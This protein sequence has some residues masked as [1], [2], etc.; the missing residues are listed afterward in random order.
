[1]ANLCGDCEY[2]NMNDCR[3]G[4]RFYCSKIGKYISP[5]NSACSNLVLRNK[6]DNGYQRSGCFITTVVC[7]ILGYDDDCEV[8][9][10]LRNFRDNF[11]KPN[12][13]Y[14][15]ILQEYD[16]VGPIISEAILHEDN[17]V[18]IAKELLQE[19]IIPCTLEIKNG[20]Y[21]SAFWTY[22][23]MVMLLKNRYNLN[24][25]PINIMYD[26]PIEDLGKGRIRTINDAEKNTAF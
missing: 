2:L 15:Y 26:T 9:Y 8:L 4:D 3:W 6:K 17:P 22:T 14:H 12:P 19:Y 7:N 5:N 23:L 1:M 18:L 11:L 21:A 16:Q 24:N 13:T 10:L 20:N 25:I